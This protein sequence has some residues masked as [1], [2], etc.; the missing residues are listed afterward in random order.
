MILLYNIYIILYE[1]YECLSVLRDIFKHFI[2]QLTVA[3]WRRR[4]KHRRNS[5]S[6]HV[7]S[8]CYLEQAPPLLSVTGQVSARNVLNV[9]LL[10]SHVSSE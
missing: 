8:V 6:N 7:T 4:R 3:G 9:R 1:S 5:I 10:M 2:A